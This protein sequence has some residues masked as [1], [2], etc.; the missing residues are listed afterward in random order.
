MEY[1][2]AVYLLAAAA[3][4]AGCRARP[5]LLVSH[6]PNPCDVHSTAGRRKPPFP[7]MWYYR[8]EVRNDTDQPIRITQFECYFDRGSNWVPGNILN[9][10]LTATDFSRWYTE[11]ARV[12]RG[13]IPP[14]TTAVCDPNW[15]GMATPSCPRCKWTFDG[16]DAKGKTYHAEAEIESVPVKQGPTDQRHP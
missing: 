11:G 5:G 9:R 13:W 10:P 6:S 2:R 4:L 12:Q 16:V 3:C 8:T 7:Y 1:K 15:H 14:H